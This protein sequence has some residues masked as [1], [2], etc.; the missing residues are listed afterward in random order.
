V[1][2]FEETRSD[3]EIGRGRWVKREERGGEIKI[4]NYSLSQKV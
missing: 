2:S 1:L 4:F 3:G